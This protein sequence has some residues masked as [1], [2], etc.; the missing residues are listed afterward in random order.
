[1]LVE[2]EERYKP[3]RHLNHFRTLRG[4]K[5]TSTSFYCFWKIKKEKTKSSDA[6]FIS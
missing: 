3:G 4:Q 5:Q 2:G 1:M 6:L